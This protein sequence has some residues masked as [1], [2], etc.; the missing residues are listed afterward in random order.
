M[1]TTPTDQLVRHL[2]A[3][4]AR[5]IAALVDRSTT[6]DDPTVLVAAALVIPHGGRCSSEQARTAATPPG[7]R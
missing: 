7:V 2:I 4:N 5:A 6:S 3:G 1:D